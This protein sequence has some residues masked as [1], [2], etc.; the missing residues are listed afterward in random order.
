VLDA[1]AHAEECCRAAGVWEMLLDVV[2]WHALTGG[3]A[4]GDVSGGE[5]AWLVEAAVRREIFDLGQVGRVVFC[6]F[7]LHETSIHER[8]PRCSS[9]TRTS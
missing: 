7:S 1:E 5:V 3:R 4:W 9:L 2:G 6:L 8:G